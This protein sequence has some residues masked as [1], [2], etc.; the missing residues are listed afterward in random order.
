M[1]PRL[2][3]WLFILPLLLPEASAS[4]ADGGGW[5]PLFNGKD[6][7]GW[8]S[9]LGVPPASVEIPGLKR[10]PDGKYHK[11]LGVDHDPLHTFSV[12][13]VDGAPAI[14]MTGPLQGGLTTLESFGNYDLK[15]QFKWG[16]RRKDQRADQRPNSGFLYHA[17][18]APGEVKGRWMNSHQFQIAEGHTGD[19]IAMGEAA[20]GIHARSIDAKHCVFDPAAGE[21]NFG[22]DEK[23]GPYCY[24]SGTDYEKPIGQWNTLE[25]ICL[26]DTCIQ[27]VNG[28]V[29]MRLAASRRREG[30]NYAPLTAGRLELDL[31][32]WEIYFREIE[33]RPIKKIPAEYAAH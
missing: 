18:G 30:K 25:I 28:H 21:V 3:L 27:V 15:F 32:G 19:Y 1:K 33:I 26:G 14:R 7:S 5:R 31:E 17:F 24:Q 13:Q 9:Y 23:V 6:L 10:G 29:T 2:P 12:V 11:P 22:N 16:E 8:E 4:A 20:A